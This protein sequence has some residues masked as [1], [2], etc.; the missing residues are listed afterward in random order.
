MRFHCIR[1]GQT[2]DNALDIKGRPEARLSEK[3]LEQ[4]R[5]LGRRFARDGVAFD[6]IFSS[7]LIRAV[8]TADAIAGSMGVEVEVCPGLA[9]RDLG[10]LTGCSGDVFREWMERESWDSRPAGGESLLDLQARVGGE[11]SR[12]K[13]RHEGKKVLIVIHQGVLRV[14]DTAFGGVAADEAMATKGYVACAPYEYEI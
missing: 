9:A 13:E 6:R 5:E 11:L 12:I 4:A 2:E 3:G 10:E 7:P 14:L 8:Q 1:H